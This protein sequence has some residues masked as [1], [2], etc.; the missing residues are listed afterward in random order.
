MAHITG[1]GVEGNLPRVLPEGVSAE[2]RWSSWRVPKV[3]GVLQEH[4]GIGLD[5]MLRVFNMGLGMVFVTD[6]SVEMGPLCPYAVQIGEIV[7]REDRRVI[8]RGLPA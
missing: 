6:S 8:L 5:E 3:F 4:G 7:P 1:G 2:L